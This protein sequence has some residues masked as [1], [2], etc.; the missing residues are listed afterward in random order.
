MWQVSRAAGAGAGRGVGRNRAGAAQRASGV[1]A[2][3]ADGGGLHLVPWDLGGGRGSGAREEHRK[4]TR[5]APDKGMAARKGAAR[6]RGRD[7]LRGPRGARSGCKGATGPR[8][9]V[10][11]RRE[12]RRSDPPKQRLLFAAQLERR[13]PRRGLRRRPPRLGALPGRERETRA[14][15][16]TTLKHEAPPGWTDRWRSFMAAECRGEMR[17]PHARPHARLLA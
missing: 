12:R 8:P 2:D 7:E 13:R 6:A 9:A 1:L 15:S 5:S 16:G 17:A 10:G 3:L 4:V 14:S 11:R